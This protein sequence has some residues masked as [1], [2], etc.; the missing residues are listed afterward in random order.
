VGLL[1]T[2]IDPGLGFVFESRT[3]GRAAARPYLE[4]S[5]LPVPSIAAMQVSGMDIIL[6]AT[7]GVEGESYQVLS[8][9][10]PGL[11]LTQWVPLASSILLANGSFSMTVTNGFRGA[12]EQFFMLVTH[13][14]PEL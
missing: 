10:N 6:S 1:L 7:N 11:P 9:P 12:S 8:S 4:I 5:A 2:A 14:Q 3:V 13:N